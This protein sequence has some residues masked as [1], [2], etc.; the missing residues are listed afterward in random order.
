MDLQLSQKLF[1]VTGATSGFGQAIAEALVAEK[2]QVIIV[3]RRAALAEALVEKHAGFVEAVVG[4]IMLE[5]TM[6]EVII[7]V[8]SRKLSGVL[9][10][11]GGPP[12]MSSLETKIEHWDEAYRG[13]LRWK[14]LFT[15]KLLPHFLANEYGRILFIESISVKQPVENLV[16]SNSLRLAV[17]GYVKT[18]SNEIG[19][20]GITVNILAP[21]YHD[22]PAME[23]LFAKK[24]A[25]LGIS[26]EE[27]RKI[28]ESEILSGKMGEAKDFASLA[29]WLLSETSRYITGQTIS[30]DGGLMKGVMG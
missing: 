21:G 6:N 15:Q 16:L 5:E 22:T 23:R 29:V 20:R 25:L 26:P 12:A 3:G 17:V 19:D 30:V 11:A 2:A 14:V 28:F 27:A 10:N 7:K 24:S 4:D 18:L 9:V 1:I 8:G 13:L